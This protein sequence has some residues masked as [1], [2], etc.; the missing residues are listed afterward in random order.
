MIVV[1]VKKARITSF[2]E[3]EGDSDRVGTC[4]SVHGFRICVCRWK[5]KVL[6]KFVLKVTMETGV[7]RH[8]CFL[9]HV[10]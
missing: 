2:D 3:G 1:N 4:G 9:F 8:G 5:V 6:L 7:N 10:F